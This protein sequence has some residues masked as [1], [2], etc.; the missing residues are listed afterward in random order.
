MSVENLL[1]GGKRVQ[2]REQGHQG[3]AILVEGAEE[4]SY[5]RG[6]PTSDEDTNT[7]GRGRTEPPGSRQGPQAHSKWVSR[8]LLRASAQ[9]PSGWLLLAACPDAC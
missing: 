2:G 5:Q 1:E 9:G 4:L 3:Q 7:E 8:V 6:C